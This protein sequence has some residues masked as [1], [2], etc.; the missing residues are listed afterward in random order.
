MDYEKRQR[1]TIILLDVDG[2]LVY[3]RGYRAGIVATVNH[4]AGQLGLQGMAPTQEEIDALHA[5]GFTNEWDLNPFV[6][7]VL[8]L[9]ATGGAPVQRPDYPDWGRRAENRAGRPSQRALGVLLEGLAQLALPEFRQAEL[10]ADLES[11]LADTYSV[12]RCATTQV[13]QEFVLG[14]Q[15]YGSHY[16]LPPRFS[17]PSLLLEEDEPALDSAGKACLERLV[18]EQGAQVCVYT[19]RPSGPPATIDPSAS[20]RDDPSIPA[21]ANSFPLAPEAELA[22]QL[23]GLEQYPLVAMGRMQWLA[24]RHG[25][26]VESLTK[27]SPAQM[28][29]ALGAA[30]SGQESV[31]LEAAYA[32]YEHSQIQEPLDMLVDAPFEIYVLEDAVPG[33]QAAAGGLRILEAQGIQAELRGIGVTRS[34]A[35]AHA[36]APFCR[37]IVP[38][39]NDGLKWI[40][41]DLGCRQV[42]S[43]GGLARR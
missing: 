3:D 6:V 19:A 17:S 20:E 25:E 38:N 22:V 15:L 13:Q 21:G 35:K 8:Q 26:T 4:F 9:A 39:V 27:P 28:L 33:L 2:V 10:K 32:L 36:L 40:E 5:S 29:A 18:A 37:T 30:L 7:G 16:G 12:R 34:E 41:L 14:S 31:A 23:V 11:L 1:R 42:E 43:S 24:D